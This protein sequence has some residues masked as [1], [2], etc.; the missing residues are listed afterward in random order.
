[1]LCPNA[2]ITLD[3]HSKSE[4]RLLMLVTSI[5]RWMAGQL[6]TMAHS[7][8]QSVLM[9]FVC[10]TCK[11]YVLDFWQ[12][13]ATEADESGIELVVSIPICWEDHRFD[14]IPLGRGRCLCD[15]MESTSSMD[16]SD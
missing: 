10:S 7:Q 1:M 11:F 3:L 13:V 8:K 15:D 16:S 9:I 4:V 12:M 5:V 6:R 2:L 14:N